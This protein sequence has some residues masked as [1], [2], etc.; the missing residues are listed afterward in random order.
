MMRAYTPLMT[1]LGRSWTNQACAAAARIPTGLGRGARLRSVS[2]RL[3]CPCHAKAS[4]RGRLETAGTP[5]NAAG[6]VQ[7]QRAD[8]ILTLE[9]IDSQPCHRTT[10]A[11]V[12]SCG[13]PSVS[14]IPDCNS[15]G[16]GVRSHGR[17]SGSNA[18]WRRVGA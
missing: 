18:A 11:I 1:S 10:G 4:R 13:V 12:L 9:R 6:V 7:W 16:G 5:P 8:D 14:R 15:R 2:S 17:Q 3:V